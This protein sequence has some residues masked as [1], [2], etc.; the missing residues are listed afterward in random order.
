[1]EEWRK[2]STKVAVTR[3]FNNISILPR[4]SWLEAVARFIQFYRAFTVDPA[5]PDASEE[6]YFWSQLP[7]DQQDQS[8]AT[9]EALQLG[10]TAGQGRG[11]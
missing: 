1:M 8:H 4:E 6:T 7:V 5:S 10:A 3:A 2:H 11:T 9:P